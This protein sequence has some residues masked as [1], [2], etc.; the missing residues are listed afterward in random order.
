MVHHPRETGSD[1]PL[2]K[3]AI[4]KRLHF[5]DE[6]HDLVTAIR[7]YGV[8]ADGPTLSFRDTGFLAEKGV[9]LHG[10]ASVFAKPAR[11]TDFW[12]EK[13]VSRQ[14]KQLNV[15]KHVRDWS[16]GPDESWVT[17]KISRL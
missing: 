4:R 3:T 2:N 13:G 8:F 17:V 5:T 10:K 6:R 16:M 12:T 14:E 7:K 9:S 11:D 15:R 1:D